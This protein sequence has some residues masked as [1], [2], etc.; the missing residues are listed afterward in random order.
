MN[1]PSWNIW[2][3]ELDIHLVDT[4]MPVIL[5]ELIDLPVRIREPSRDI[6][7]S[8]PNV[9]LDNEHVVEPEF[10]LARAQFLHVLGHRP[11]LGFR[12]RLRRVIRRVLIYIAYVTRARADLHPIRVD[13]V[14]IYNIRALRWKLIS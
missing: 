12:L 8:V 13:Y 10:F 1:H 3:L 14:V 9:Y 7:P 6:P 5:L 2:C 11:V 4:L